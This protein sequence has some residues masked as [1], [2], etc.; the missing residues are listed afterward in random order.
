MKP[1]GREKKLVGSGPWK[2]DYHP[3]PKHTVQ[4]WWENIVSLLPRST[5]KANVKKEI[6][7]E[8]S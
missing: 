1:Y 2:K 3:K 8:I 4:N 5:M 6:E 7:R